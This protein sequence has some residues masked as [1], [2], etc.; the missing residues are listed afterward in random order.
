MSLK[1]P[2]YCDTNLWKESI[3]VPT[4]PV[5]YLEIGT[6]CGKSAISFESVYGTHPDSEIHCVDPWI[7]YEQYDE[8]RDGENNQVNNYRNFLDNLTTCK[9]INK[10][11]IHRGYSHT[12]LPTF[13][14]ETFD[15]LFIDGNHKTLNVLEDG[16]MAFRKVKRGGIIIFDDV[17]LAHMGVIKAIQIYMDVFKDKV[18]F[19]N[20][21]IHSH[22][23]IKKKDN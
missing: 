5:K 20:H 22:F 12:I 17:S 6:L 18:E 3:P 21:N 7:N 19:I 10:F 13:K 2:G 1:G 15:I 8:Y 9:N 14:D 16:I 23:F 11:Y 4:G